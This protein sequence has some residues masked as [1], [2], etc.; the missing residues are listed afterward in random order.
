MMQEAGKLQ[1]GEPGGALEEPGY[2]KKP[3]LYRNN[4]LQPFMMPDLDNTSTIIK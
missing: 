1:M 2:L 3:E 4:V